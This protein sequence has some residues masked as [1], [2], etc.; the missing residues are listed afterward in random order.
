MSSFRHLNINKN[1]N[2]SVP[3]T[4]LVDYYCTNSNEGYVAIHSYPAK[5]V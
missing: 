3:F 5:Q 4:V 2:K 1:K